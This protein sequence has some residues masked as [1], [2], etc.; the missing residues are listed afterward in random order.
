MYMIRTCFIVIIETANAR[1]W[2]WIRELRK[3]W[4]QVTFERGLGEKMRLM[5]TDR[6]GER[7]PEQRTKQNEPR[8]IVAGFPP[9]SVKMSKDT[10]TV[11]GYS[12]R[13]ED[14]HLAVGSQFN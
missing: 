6:V 12:P 9:Y 13:A 8:E 5:S 2:G 1:A 14:I 10:L 11:G 3:T 4:R 7:G